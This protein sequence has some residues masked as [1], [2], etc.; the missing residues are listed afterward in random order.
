MGTI[1]KHEVR[2][3][4]V[5]S[6]VLL[7]V[8]SAAMVYGTPE[9]RTSS[10]PL[11]NDAVAMDGVDVVITGLAVRTATGYEV[12][13]NVTNHRGSS[14]SIK[15]MRAFVTLTT[16]ARINASCRGPDAVAP[17]S[18]GSFLV[19]FEELDDIEIFV[20]D[21]VRGE[22]YLRAIMPIASQGQHLPDPPKVE[23]APEEPLPGPKEET[24]LPG[25]KEETPTPEPPT[26]DP[27]VPVR[28]EPVVSLR[29]DETL[30]LRPAYFDGGPPLFGEPVPGKVIAKVTRAGDAADIAVFVQF[31]DLV[32]GQVIVQASF[33]SG[34][35]ITVPLISDGA[36]G[37]Y[38]VLVDEPARA[39]GN[40]T[41][42]YD[43]VSIYH[44]VTLSVTT[45]KLGMHG[46]RLYAHDAGSG[47]RIS[48]VAATSYSIY[49][50][51]G[52]YGMFDTVMATDIEDP[53]VPGKIYN[54]SFADSCRYDQYRGEVRSVLKCPHASSVWLIGTDGSET[55]LTANSLGEYIV[56]W[57]HDGRPHEVHVRVQ[58]GEDN[59]A[60]Q[61]A[62][63]H[64]WLE[65]VSTGMALSP[66]PSGSIGG[67]IFTVRG[68]EPPPDPPPE[69]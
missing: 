15:D 38:G 9:T 4:V 35:S 19:V 21:L 42:H 34:P 40:W 5:S 10:A 39:G 55:L 24:P 7:I 58:L 1:R 32:P 53:F 12:P 49:G 20:I 37:C 57:T 47:A 46:M 6:L 16:M 50:S 11:T 69:P 43:G 54:I 48:D 44:N 30:P 51:T 29:I 45:F 33:E 17:G 56:V 8:L 52:A 3:L 65:D 61:P 59:G 26:P 14:I 31:P 36:A 18:T 22:H 27:E 28:A 68:P 23:E 67:T 64:Y 13:M 63:G 62:D 2:V 25:P 66:E 41:W 60:Y